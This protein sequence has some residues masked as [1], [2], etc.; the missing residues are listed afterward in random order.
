MKKIFYLTFAVAFAAILVSCGGNQ[1]NNTD[2]NI[3]NDSV[4]VDTLVEDIEIVEIDTVVGF[5]VG[6]EN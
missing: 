5:V 3:V 4:Y 6:E 1:I 2:T